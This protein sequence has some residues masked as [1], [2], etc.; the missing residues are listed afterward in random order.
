MRKSM[1][2]VVVPI[3]ALL[4]TACG[5]SSPKTTTTHA[6]TSTSSASSSSSVTIST[7]TIKPYGAV[8][9]NSVGRTLYVFEPDKAKKVT[10]VGACA[11]IWPPT[12][13][14]AGAKPAAAGGVKASLLGSDAN[15]SGGRVVTYNGWPLYTYVTDTAP[16]EAHG[17]GINS[18]GGLWYVISPRA[19]SSRRSHRRRP[20]PRAGTDDLDRPAHMCAGPGRACSARDDGAAHARPRYEKRGMGAAGIESG[21]AWT[22]RSRTAPWTSSGGCSSSWTSGSTRRRRSGASR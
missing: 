11:T 13:L 10:C 22:S 21:P 5:S 19:R 8:L 14:A 3:A 12:K 6:K 18:S 15:P 4:A 16:G 17:Q 20:R 7:R 2:M 9:V 1:L